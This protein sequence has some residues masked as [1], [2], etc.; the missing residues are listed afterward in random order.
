[1]ISND[2]GEGYWYIP[3]S[4]S[5]SATR[6]SQQEQGWAHPQG[7][8]LGGGRNL[9]SKL[10]LPR[11]G[12][13]DGVLGSMEAADGANA[14]SEESHHN[15]MDRQGAMRDVPL[16]PSIVEGP[17]GR[18]RLVPTMAIVPSKPTALHPRA[19][20]LN[21]TLVAPEADQGNRE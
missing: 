3:R 16:P 12:S 19:V 9:A 15:V 11:P 2:D 14:C 7:L 21:P 18:S 6:L 5:K 1:M 8:G 20:P 17:D 13:T 4:R 10:S